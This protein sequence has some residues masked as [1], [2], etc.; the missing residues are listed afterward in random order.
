MCLTGFGPNTKGMLIMDR[1]LPSCCRRGGQCCGSVCVLLVLVVCTAKAPAAGSVAVIGAG[2]GH[3]YLCAALG[4][5]GVECTVFPNAGPSESLDTFDV[6]IILSQVWTDPDG[7]LTDVMRAG[8][9]II[10]WGS[11]PTTLGIHNDPT[12]RAWIGANS[13]GVTSGPLHTEAF[14]PILGLRPPGTQLSDCGLGLCAA[15]ADTAGHPD[16]KVLASFGGAIGILRNRWEGGQSVYF[17]DL[18]TGIPPGPEL[19]VNAVRELRPPPPI[20]A[21]SQWGLA[22]MTLLVVAAGTVVMRRRESVRRLAHR[23]GAT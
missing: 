18:I 10:L 4:D 3:A 14:D 8:H 16:A 22:V 13:W 5:L 21:V 15:M 19:F 6:V 9:G 2:G 23:A 11:A 7:T 17:T 1:Q 20:P 12:V